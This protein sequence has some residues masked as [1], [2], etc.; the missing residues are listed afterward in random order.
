ML[1]VHTVKCLQDNYSYVIHNESTNL[2]GV[3]DPSEFY[4]IDTFVKKKFNKLDYILNTHHHFDHTGG[5][6]ELK[7]KI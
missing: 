4:P 3:V 5:N 7:E 6:L 1:K 2:V